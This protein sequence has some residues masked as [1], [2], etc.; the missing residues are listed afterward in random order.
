MNPPHP[1]HSPHSIGEFARR[2]RLTVVALR[3]YD[4]VGLLTPARV[5]RTTG[6]RYYDDEQVDDA[7]R[8]GL[9]RSLGVPVPLLADWRNG[10]RALSDLL[11]EHRDRLAV[12]ISERR[13]ALAA[14]DALDT[15]RAPRRP[16]VEDG[17]RTEEHVI[18]LTTETT[19]SGAGS[20]TRFALARLAVLL[21]RAG[22]DTPP[23]RPGASFPIDPDERIA[24][25]VFV[26]SNAP[27][28]RLPAPLAI[29]TIPAGPVLRAEH[30]GDR[31]LLPFVYRTLLAEAA[32]RALMVGPDV[33]E[34]YDDGDG[35][36]RT[37][38]SIGVLAT[39]RAPGPA[40][41]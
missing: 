9:L 16:H 24:V 31:R 26:R 18:A 14:L 8:L 19:W 7:I 5:D 39:T 22:G 25:R 28:E 15:D 32:R 4:R 3:Y 27:V 40:S 2:T 23:H 12:E 21:R 29:A 11:D 36:P 38:V 35:A 13:A 33:Y 20:A 1:P 41:R 10:R 37:I 6:Y 30:H 34:D 17:E